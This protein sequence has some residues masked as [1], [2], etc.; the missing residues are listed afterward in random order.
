MSG[1]PPPP[2]AAVGLPIADQLLRRVLAPVLVGALVFAIPLVVLTVR[3][4][5]G[6]LSQQAE[7][8]A[9]TLAL[10]AGDLI[11]AADQDRIT[12]LEPLVPEERL[13]IVID[14]RLSL[15]N[16]LL[17]PAILGSDAVAGALD[18]DIGSQRL[19]DLDVVVGAAPVVEDARSIGAA[20]TVLPTVEADRQ[21][22]G[23]LVLLAALGIGLSAVAAWS[24]RSFARSIVRPVSR[25][26][27][28]AAQ[29]AAGDL[30]V[31]APTDAGP[32]EL[33]RLATT[34]NRSV[35]RLQTLLDQ[36][37]RFV[38]DASHQLRTPLT[39]L[40]LRLETAEAAA[41]RDGAE[42]AR[43]RAA[44]AEVDR[45]GELVDDLLVLARAEV[46]RPEPVVE[47]VVARVV[48][49]VAT[50]AP[51]GAEQKVA[52]A[53]DLPDGAVT[54]WAL[55]GSLDQML[56][57]LIANALRVAPAESEVTV[58]VRVEDDRAVVRVT[59]RGPG[60]SAEQR[61]RAFDRFWRAPDAGAGGSGLGLAIVRQLVEA[62]GGTVR[63]R[64][65]TG[66]GLVAEVALP[67]A[68]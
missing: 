33:R 29:L 48:G 63:L 22:R 52:V 67:I 1:P 5:R 30:D 56:D 49:R 65:H 58:V 35:D 9:A 26:D 24:S 23:T 32:P 18:G 38:A 17:P 45:L 51:V 37:R 62:G 36:Q 39:G 21:T 25:L 10:L 68:T 54:A 40:R 14:G 16:A 57:D 13:A 4:T 46:D 6:Q 34:L 43:L 66:G 42:L 31:R 44:I 64:A 3:D 27:D 2:V 47:D 61:V 8:R 53:A 7:L 19:P 11:A 20:I 28:V 60:L 12:R 15:G 55:P 50:W 59:D 41:D